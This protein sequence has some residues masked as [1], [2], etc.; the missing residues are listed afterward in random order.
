MRQSSAHTH[1]NGNLSRVYDSASPGNLFFLLPLSNQ[2]AWWAVLWLAEGKQSKY[3]N[4]HFSPGHEH[5][6]THVCGLCVVVAVGV[7]VANHYEGISLRKMCDIFKWDIKIRVF[8]AQLLNNYLSG[9]NSCGGTTPRV[10]G[11]RVIADY[12]YVTG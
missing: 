4:K 9:E 12:A 3:V 7:L 2:R 5:C 6:H 11:Q 8:I 10:R 1:A